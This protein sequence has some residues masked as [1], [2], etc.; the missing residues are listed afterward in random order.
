MIRKWNVKLLLFTMIGE[1]GLKYTHITQA[2][3]IRFFK[4]HPKFLCAQTMKTFTWLFYPR[5]TSTNYKILISLPKKSFRYLAGTVG[6][7]FGI[8]C[9]DKNSS[10]SES[11]VRDWLKTRI[12]SPN[13]MERFINFIKTT[14]FPDSSTMLVA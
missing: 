13:S 12:R 1:R 3:I 10:I 6:S 4:F 7:L 14:I 9:W 5:A 8:Y 11:V 2:E